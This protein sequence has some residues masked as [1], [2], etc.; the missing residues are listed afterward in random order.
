MKATRCK[1]WKAA[2][3]AKMRRS[4]TPSERLLRKHLNRTPYRWKF[5]KVLLGYI[6]DFYCPRY[7]VVVE[8]DGNS[9]DNRQAEDRAR[10]AILRKKAGII[11][12]RFSASTVLNNCQKVVNE[13]LR[14]F[15]GLPTYTHPYSHRKLESDK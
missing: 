7:R 11:T 1:P 5:Q 14:F 2:F 12:L 15:V 9:H 3:A 10:D 13:I 4:P 6:V 8:V